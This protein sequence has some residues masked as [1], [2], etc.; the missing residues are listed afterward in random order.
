MNMKPT[1]L[2]SVALLLVTPC[3]AQSADPM[4]WEAARWG[5]TLEDLKALYGDQL[6]IREGSGSATMRISI[7]ET[8]AYGLMVT[9]TFIMDR[10]ERLCKV[11]LAPVDKR[12]PA[13]WF[14]A[15][16]SALAAVYGPPSEEFVEDE[17]ADIRYTTWPFPTTEIKLTLVNIGVGAMTR[18]DFDGCGDGSSRAHHD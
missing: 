18:L 2:L 12:R 6:T 13:A 5:M 8:E 11:N 10:K 3:Y 4:G 7:P 9:V 1:L 17:D 14:E 15:M 16:A